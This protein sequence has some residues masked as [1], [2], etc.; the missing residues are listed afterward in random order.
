MTEQPEHTSPL[1]M[2]LFTANSVKT[3]NIL[4]SMVRLQGEPY[5][6]EFFK[7][8]ILQACQFSL[9]DEA[10]NYYTSDQ[11]V[12]RWPSVLRVGNTAID[13]ALIMQGSFID[14]LN[15]ILSDCL[16]NLEGVSSIK[17][18]LSMREENFISSTLIC[19]LS[20]SYC[21]KQRNIPLNFEKCAPYLLEWLKTDGPHIQKSTSYK[22][23]V[24]RY[25]TKEDLIKFF[26]SPL[27]KHSSLM[28]N[29]SGPWSLKQELL[30]FLDAADLKQQSE[31]KIK[32]QP[33]KTPSL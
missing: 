4:R 18:D 8:S 25:D 32:Y 7:Q 26:N 11:M 17:K 2:A 27:K 3:V 24:S 29:E 21:F 28:K 31:G 1:S 20:L 12:I 10:E 33:M 14:S 22:K 9:N 6:F 15:T 5:T 23:M 19:F 30:S 13:S 16:Q